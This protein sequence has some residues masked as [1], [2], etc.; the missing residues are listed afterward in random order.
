MRLRILGY[1]LGAANIFGSLAVIQFHDHD[2]IVVAGLLVGVQI[3]FATD[4][5]FKGAVG[6]QISGCI[7]GFEFFHLNRVAVGIAQFNC[8]RQFQ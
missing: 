8:I 5:D 6:I 2:A 7:A 1:K 4:F 3:D